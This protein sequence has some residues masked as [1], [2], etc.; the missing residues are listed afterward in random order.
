MWFK[1]S[2][3]ARLGACA[4]ENCWGQPTWRL[5]AG[6]VGSN[7]CSGCK[8]R[9]VA[10]SLGMSPEELRRE[11]AMAEFMSTPLRQGNR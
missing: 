11:T 6:G 7:Y 3:D 4:S 1:L 2:G 10:S 8:E 5:E 9:I